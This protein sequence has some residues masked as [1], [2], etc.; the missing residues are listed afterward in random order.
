M[1]ADV[2]AELYAINK[3]AARAAVRRRVGHPARHRPRH[4]P[5]RH[6]EQLRTGRPRAQASAPAACITC[7]A[8]RKPIA[9]ASA[10]GP[11][12][13]NSTSRP[14]RAWRA[15]VDQGL[16]VRHRHRPQAPLQL[17]SISPR[18]SARSSSTATG[19]CITK[20]DV[21]DGLEEL[22]R[23]A[24]CSTA[25]A[26]TCS[27][28][29][30]RRSCA[31]SR[32]RDPERLEWH[33]VW[34]AELGRPSRRRRAPHCTA[35]RRSARSRSTSF[36]PVPS[37][38]KPS[39]AAIPL[40]PGASVAPGCTCGRAS[41][42][43]MHP[44]IPARRPD[45]RLEPFLHGANLRRLGNVAPS[46]SVRE[47]RAVFRATRADPRPAPAWRT[48]LSRDD[49]TKR[50]KP[51]GF[52]EGRTELHAPQRCTRNLVHQFRHLG[53]EAHNSKG[54]SAKVFL[55]H[56]GSTCRRGSEGL[57]VTS[58]CRIDPAQHAVFPTDARSRPR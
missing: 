11:S 23:L 14:G 41:P 22:P 4:L 27:R 56:R 16:R 43:A 2:S 21:L 50:K 36:R 20:L 46:G 52:P 18:S 30:R 57:P 5:L 55:H 47:F 8:S 53:R 26:S 10:A 3:S 48:F 39:S 45:L 34:R 35:S 51:P 7:S 6:L 42:G 38:T 17:V 12:R 44:A 31:A 33:H 1:V 32:S 29:V 54:L 9:P 19:L 13:P 24:T 25:G 15:D 28:W 58:R 40:A 49:G 37:A